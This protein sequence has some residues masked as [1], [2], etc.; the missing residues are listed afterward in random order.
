M[1]FVKVLKLKQYIRKIPLVSLIILKIENTQCVPT[2][3]CAVWAVCFPSNREAE[4]YLKIHVL[5]YV[6]PIYHLKYICPSLF[7]WKE[8]LIF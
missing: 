6:Y 3:Q 8:N 2:A 5:I 1:A 4:K 7:G